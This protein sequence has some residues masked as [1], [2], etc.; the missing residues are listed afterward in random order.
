[1][2][3]TV[4]APDSGELRLLGLDPTRPD[5]RLAIRRRLP[6]AGRAI[7]V[8]SVVLGY[9]LSTTVGARL[10]VA[11]LEGRVTALA[12]P[13]GQRSGRQIADQLADA[14]HGH[15]EGGDADAGAEVAGRQRHQRQDGT[16]ADGDQQRRAVDRDRDLPPA[17]RVGGVGCHG[18]PILT[19]PS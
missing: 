12:D 7:I 6:R 15:H 10:L 1:M 3:A 19:R 11:P 18:P 5:E 9:V 8:A 4:L 14:E 17:E 2:A 13:R 16:G